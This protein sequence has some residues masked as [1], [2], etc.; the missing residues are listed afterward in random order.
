[1]TPPDRCNAPMGGTRFVCD[2]EPKHTGQHRT[3]LETVDEVVFWSPVL[4][5][6]ALIEQH[7]RRA[8]LMAQHQHDGYHPTPDEANQLANMRLILSH[9]YDALTEARTASR[10]EKDSETK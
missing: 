9:F 4:D 10:P 6:T 1:M 5:V 3:Y 7:A 8:V 2:R